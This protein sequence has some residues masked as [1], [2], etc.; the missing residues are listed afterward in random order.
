MK[1]I[2][3]WGA[4]LLVGALTIAA[5]QV[6]AEENRVMF[7]EN[8]DQLIHYTTVTRGDVTEHMLTTPEAI[9]A[10]KNGEP[11]PHGS[12]VVLVDY[13]DGKVHRY[14]IMQKGAGWGEHY[15][16][17]TGTGDWQFQWFWGDKSINMDETTSRCVS[18]H[19]SREGRQNLYTFNGM[20]R[21]EA[22]AGK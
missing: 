15:A 17:E 21:Y 10:V 4:S 11:I 12:H 16:P 19:K 8:L 13:R 18:C 3:K 14:F 22:R 20:H 9:E 2:S 1:F 6:Q 7:P 5:F